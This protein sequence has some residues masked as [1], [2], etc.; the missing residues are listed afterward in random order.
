[1]KFRRI[2]LTRPG[3]RMLVR[4]WMS[5]PVITIEAAGTVGAAARLLSENHIKRLPVLEAGRLVG[6]LSEKDLRALALPGDETLIVR[7]VMTRDPVTIGLDEPVEAAAVKMHDHEF[8][9]L[10]VIGPGGEL[11]GILTEEDV[12]EAMIAMTGARFAGVRLSLE[13]EDRPGSIQEV[14]NLIRAEG[15]K[16]LSIVTSYQGVRAGY[17]ELVLKIS[18]DHSEQIVE[19]LAGAYP[20]TTVVKV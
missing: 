9:A 20:G 14:T 18:T 8:G 12:F 11:A 1:M 15:G 6:I 10:P 2:S 19:R 5:K 7:E 16:I 3:G 4:N 17:R 13:I